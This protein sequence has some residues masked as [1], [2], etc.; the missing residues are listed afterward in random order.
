MELTSKHDGSNPGRERL[1]ELGPGVIRQV[2]FA[3]MGLC[4]CA[5]TP[6]AFGAARTQAAL[7]LGAETARP[8]ETVL[9]ITQMTDQVL[10]RLETGD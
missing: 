6:A 5:A 3:I 7:V 2:L 1:L 4:V 9:T 8:G 10:K